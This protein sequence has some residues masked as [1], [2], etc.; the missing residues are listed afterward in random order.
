MYIHNISKCMYMYTILYVT[1]SYN[2]TALLSDM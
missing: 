1:H 2:Y